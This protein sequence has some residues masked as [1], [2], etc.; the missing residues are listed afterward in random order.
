MSAES[1][2]FAV[3]RFD[4][5]IKSYMKNWVSITCDYIASLF[6]FWGRSKV[7]V[8]VMKTTF[9]KIKLKIIQFRDYTQLGNDKFTHNLLSEL[10]LQNVSTNFNGMQ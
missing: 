5:F 4:L 8:I 1:L 7:D 6:S 10:S 3:K 2:I 9:E